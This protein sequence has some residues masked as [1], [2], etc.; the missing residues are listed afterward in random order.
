MMVGAGMA[1]GIADS[2]RQVNAAM[3]DLSGSV[4]GVLP[5]MNA[6]GTVSKSEVTN[7]ISSADMFR[8]LISLFGV[9]TI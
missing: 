5:D 9:T 3:Q 4:T 6:G 7:T 8:G 1:E 2:A